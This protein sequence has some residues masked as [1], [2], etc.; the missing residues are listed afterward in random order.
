MHAAMRE[1]LKEIRKPYPEIDIQ[2]E[3]DAAGG[4]YNQQVFRKNLIF[5][6]PLIFSEISVA[7]SQLKWSPAG[8]FNG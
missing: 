1:L 2:E 5:R 4:R 8:S 7:A 6:R 3:S